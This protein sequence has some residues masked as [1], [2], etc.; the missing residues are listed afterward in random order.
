MP[1]KPEDAL[2]RVALVFDVAAYRDYAYIWARARVA[3]L[4]HDLRARGLHGVL[5]RI[6]VDGYPYPNP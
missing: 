4:D 1:D 3:D 5:V 6:D 2:C